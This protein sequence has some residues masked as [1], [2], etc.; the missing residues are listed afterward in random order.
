MTAPIKP[1]PFCGG[2]AAPNTVRYSDPMRRNGLTQEVF[3]GVNC[4]YCG[5]CNRGTVGFL[6]EADAITAWNTRTPA[7]VEPV[8]VACVEET[9]AREQSLSR[10]HRGNGPYSAAIFHDPS[11]VEKSEALAL[12]HDQRAT[13]L[14][15]ALHALT[16]TPN[17]TP[18]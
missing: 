4:I 2:E 16:N 18:K 7:P 9:V 10:Y 14:Q 3:H 11:L 15:H 5:V 1:C 6:K 13:A 17:H 8:I 12:A